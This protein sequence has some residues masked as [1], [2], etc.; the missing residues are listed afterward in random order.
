M[1]YMGIWEESCCYFVK[2]CTF[3][4]INFIYIYIYIYIL[5]ETAA[6]K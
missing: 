3:T 5:I 4:F 6:K 2:N 1:I